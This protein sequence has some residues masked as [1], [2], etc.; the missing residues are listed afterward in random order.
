MLERFRNR[1]N[2]SIINPEKKLANTSEV[3][4]K[5]MFDI[6]EEGKNKNA[7]TLR[8]DQL[9]PQEIKEQILDYVNIK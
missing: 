4:L 6:Y 2:E 7:L 9:T 5:E 1:V 3:R 8:T